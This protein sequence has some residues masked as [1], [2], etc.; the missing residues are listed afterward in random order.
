MSK[1]RVY[2]LARELKVESKALV[3]KIKE[4]GIDVSSHQSTL[5]ADQVVRIKRQFQGGSS[6]SAKSPR[7][8]RRRRKAQAAPGAESAPQDSTEQKTEVGSPESKPETEEVARVASTGAPEAPSSEVDREG[9][10]T[11]AAPAA[12][13]PR[14]EHAAPEADQSV[15][16]E[17]AEAK[18]P[19]KPQAE[20]VAE[21]AELGASSSSE[22]PKMETQAP[23]EASQAARTQEQP[24]QTAKQSEAA[25][26]KKNR[27]PQRA[28]APRSSGSA[29]IV[30]R[31]T[32]DEVAKVQRER[33]E[34]AD[35]RTQ[36][37]GERPQRGGFQGRPGNDRPRPEGGSPRGPRDRNDSRP[38][39][40]P[41]NQEETPV[42][43]AA[44]FDPGSVKESKW[45]EP[46]RD[47]KRTTKPTS[48]QEAAAAAAAARKAPPK[49]KRDHFSTRAIL[50]QIDSPEEAPVPAPAK[51]KTVYTPQAGN[52]KRDL[53]R[54]KDLKKTQITTPKASLRVVKMGHEITV[55]DLARQLS[56]KAGELIKKLMA[57]G[58]M[59]TINQNVD[60]ET[61]TLIASEYKYEVKSNLVS[62]DDIL[63]SK[64]DAYESADQQERPP[65]VTIMGHVDHG[66]TSILDALRK[67]KVAAGE[68]GGI[69]QHIG[70]Y[71]VEKDGRKVAFL[72]TPGHEAF[73][74][75]RSRGAQVTDIVILV[76]AA[77]DGVM[78]QTV[79]AISHAKD[80][81]VPIIVA[82]N[83]IDKPNINLDRVY[84][85]LTEHG[86]QSEEWGGDTQF[87]KVSALQG[88]GLDDL[89][90]AVLLQSEIL[91]LTAATDVPGTGAVV[92]AHLDKGRGPVA[93]VMIREGTLRVGDHVVAG[94]KVGRVRAMTN[95]LGKR[96]KS[97][98]PS[99]PVEI[100]GLSEVPMAGD[101]IDVVEGERQARE[102]AAWR[103]EQAAA[104]ASGKSSAA[105]LE[106]LLSKVKDA[107]TPEVPVIVKA[108]T[109][110][111]VEAV[112]EAVMKLNT[113][114]VRN[115][116]VHKAVGGINESD[117]SLAETSGAVV[118][119]FN[120]RAARGLD[121]EAEKRGVMV[122]Y[123]S[124]IYEIV[125]ALKAV[126]A[127]KLPPIQREVVI[128]H[129]EVRQTIKVPKVG[130]VA[131]TAITD[132]KVV[133][134]SNVR[135][136]REDV[137]VYSGKLGSLKRFKDDVKE[138]AQG[139]ECG[140]GIDGYNDI[141][142]GDIIEAFVIEEEAATL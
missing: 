84:T 30:R 73:S 46:R 41:R 24:K 104:M 51:K 10:Q 113:D 118:V 99:T 109:Q 110:G 141:R 40:P 23:V 17:P 80:A 116:V 13:S 132:G 100:V 60:F 21:R 37:G 2:E 117:L 98:G 27:E 25:A 68:A 26:E 61:A 121:E 120:V 4:M 48:E 140:I 97:A 7:V 123:F 50:S 136:I 15:S 38:P 94:T 5:S 53:K 43:P 130:L 20:P 115:R 71:S 138:V 111:S 76:V 45:G 35:R 18:E 16:E 124:V 11:T 22:S 19:E 42:S 134:N 34:R 29:T 96:L 65:I 62:L 142:I 54:R 33:A 82:V 67:A 102:V 95:H 85:E 91:E 112:T 81:G 1:V 87:V 14:A 122:K 78:P 77:D 93:T 75:M 64:K 8:I 32:K 119:A 72:D 103:E 125:D 56:V 106:E 83:K 47:K 131:G 70:A 79:E 36:R 74:A 101:T 129:A 9:E 86:I 63:S 59:A 128:G 6:D 108:D 57:E 66:K 49:Q 107:D 39:R 126:M 135:L 55:G 28:A 52:R 12:E 92:E 88:T 44:A 137:V 31:A 58:V 105:S 127:G 89:I 3:P 139:Y 133:R 69:T 114:K 90:E